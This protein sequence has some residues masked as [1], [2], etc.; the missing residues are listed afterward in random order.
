MRVI[1]GKARGARLT[2][3]PGT[4]TR[5]TTDKVKEAIFSMIGEQLNG[6]WV[7]DLF[8]GTGGLAIEAL[9]RGMEHAVLIDKERASIQVIKQNLAAA[10]LTDKAEVYLNE[11][12]R[13]LKPLHRRGVHFDLV[14]LDPPYRMQ[15]MDVWVARM[16]GMQLLAPGARIVIEHDAQTTYPAV[17][18]EGAATTTVPSGEEEPGDTRHAAPDMKPM[19]AA[20]AMQCHLVKLSYYGETAISIYAMDDSIR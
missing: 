15:D 5:P 6:G 11:A 8:A 7:L 13:A 1:A 9:S 19:H 4:K 3:V 2:A 10:H 14:L 20:R 12:G 16:L 17:I 18:G